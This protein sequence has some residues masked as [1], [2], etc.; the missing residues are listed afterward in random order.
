MYLGEVILSAAATVAIGLLCMLHKRLTSMIM[1]VLVSLFTLGIFVCFAGSLVMKEGSMSPSFVP[2]SAALSQIIKIAVISPWAF[3]GFESVSHATDELSFEHNKIHKVL[4]ISVISTL[5]LYAM[6]TLLSVTAYPDE[7]D[8]W[9]SYIKDLDNLEGLKALPAFYAANRYLGVFGTASL[10][11]LLLA[12]V[13]TSLI[14]NISALS[15][16]FYSMAKDRILPEKIS[17]INNRGIPAK[18]IVLVVTISAFIPFVG[19]TAIGWI[20]DVTT[21]GAT[22]IYGF[23]SAA[24]ARLA[25]EMGDKRERRTGIAG[26]LLMIGFGAYIIL[27]NIISKGTMA[28]ETYFLFIVW[29]VLGF[30]FFRFILRHDKEKRFGASVSVWV[31]LL[32]LVLMISLIWMRQSMIRSNEKME[33]NVRSYYAQSDAS[34]GQRY[35]DEQYIEGQMDERESENARTIVMAVGMFGF[36]LVIMLTNHSYLNKRSRESELLANTDSMTGA[37]N[38]HAY[39]VR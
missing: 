2:D 25:K 30:L 36:A 34:D 4:I 6:V 11:L 9:L 29:S 19:R 37:R 14:G 20:V 5:A 8:S 17:S 31:A 13:I 3:I 22:L 33:D 26:L 21:I 28:T 16:L 18:A 24:A 7:Y 12:L 1:I 15:R 32:S 39:M 27:P 35:D 23:V 10:T 38:K